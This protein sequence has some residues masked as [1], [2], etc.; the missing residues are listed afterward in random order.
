MSSSIFSREKMIAILR[1]S[2][3][4]LWYSILLTILGVMLYGIVEGVLIYSKGSDYFPERFLLRDFLQLLPLPF[5]VQGIQSRTIYQIQL[6]LSILGLALLSLMLVQS[7]HSYRKLQRLQQEILHLKRSQTA[8][9]STTL[10]GLLRKWS[11]EQQEALEE[12]LKSYDHLHQEQIQTLKTQQEEWIDQWYHG[13]QHTKDQMR[14][15]QE[16]QQRS[17]GLLLKE[18]LQMMHDQSPTKSQPLSHS[19]KKSAADRVTEL[20]KSKPLETIQPTKN[21]STTIVMANHSTSEEAT[22]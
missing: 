18:W 15:W 11:Q 6:P 17:L 1:F 20:T 2:T 13:H 5:P 14:H 9:E 4:F 8:I 22:P 7:W 16:S 21:R 12:T 10:Q 3:L 19:A